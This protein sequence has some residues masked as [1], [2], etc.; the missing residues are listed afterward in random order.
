VPGDDDLWQLATVA[1]YGA[2]AIVAARILLGRA[3]ASL[4]RRVVEQSSAIDVARYRTQVSLLRRVTYALIVAIT[5]WKALAVFDGTRN[6]SQAILASGAL[7]ALFIGLAITTPLQ[8]VGSG[9]LVVLTQKVRLGD[10]V[11]VGGETGEV[12]QIHLVHT[13]LARPDGGRVFVPNQVM[14][15][16]I[17]VNRTIAQAPPAAAVR[18]PI[19]LAAALPEARAVVAEA[20]AAIA[21][22]APAQVEVVVVDADDRAAVLE[23]RWSPATAADIIPQEPAA[24][25]AALTALAGRGLLPAP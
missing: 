18:V 9:V 2:V 6:V 10:Q 8:N 20:V 19:A 13:I 25:E 17:V 12:E 16:T 11:T 7:L 21:G 24:R 23:A 1:A 3:V 5:A 15:A 4:G 22:V 14:L